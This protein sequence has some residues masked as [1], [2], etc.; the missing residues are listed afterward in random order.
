MFRSGMV[1]SSILTHMLRSSLIN[2]LPP[3][4]ATWLRGS[5]LTTSR[6]PR[7]NGWLVLILPH[8]PLVRSTGLVS[9]MRGRVVMCTVRPGMVPICWLVDTQR[10]R[11]R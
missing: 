11:I 5:R 4:S 3:F 6:P 9:L 7:P 8:L 10:A 2:Q 1:T